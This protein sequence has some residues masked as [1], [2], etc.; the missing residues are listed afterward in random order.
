[1]GVRASRV[2][3]MLI[4]IQVSGNQL[5]GGKWK[6]KNTVVVQIIR[7]PMGGLYKNVRLW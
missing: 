7:T 2:A 3:A 1:M 4:V 6:V 5:S